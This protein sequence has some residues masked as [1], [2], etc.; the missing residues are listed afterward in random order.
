[1][2][3]PACPQLMMSKSK[4]P[5]GLVIDFEGKLSAKGLQEPECGSQHSC[6]DYA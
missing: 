4:S 2:L 6:V 5:A 1:M 3:A